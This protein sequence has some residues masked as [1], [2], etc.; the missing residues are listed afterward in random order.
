MPD[1]E[2]VVARTRRANL[3]IFE[4]VERVW[5]DLEDLLMDMVG[6]DGVDEDGGEVPF[7]GL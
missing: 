6:L 7:R 4:R 1:S 3:G 5:E 2:V